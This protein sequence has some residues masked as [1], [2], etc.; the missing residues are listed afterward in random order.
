MSGLPHAGQMLAAQA[1]LQPNRIGARDLDRELTFRA[2]NERA[3]RLANALI[4]MG[5][6]KGDRV[7]VFAFNRMEWA[8][9]Y[10]AV[11][12][13]GVVAVPINFRLTPNEALFICRDCAISAV[14]AEPDL[15]PTVDAIRDDL[16]LASDRFILMG[17]TAAPGW[18]AYEDVLLKGAA[19]DPDVAIDSEDPWCLM[20]TSGTTGNPKGAIRSHRGMAMLALMTQ[21]ELGLARRDDALLVM[22]MCHANSLNFFTSFLAIGAAVT[23]FS[24][25]SFDP[26]LCLSTIG[27]IGVTFSSMVPTHYMMMLD[28]PNRSA[29]GFERVEKLMVSSAPARVE[30]KRA[31]MEMF[32]R[33]KLFELYGSTEAGWV[34]F[35]HPDEL[36]DHLGTVGREVTGSA[37]IRMLDDDGNE[38]PDGEVG[39]LYSCSPYAF[40]GYWNLP[41]KTAEAFRGDYLTVGDMALR[42]EHGFIKL[43]DRKKN[44][45]ITGGENVYP[46]EVESVLSQH[47]AVRDV[48][49]VGVED[50]QW[51]ERVAAAVVC[52]PGVDVSADSLLS[53]ARDRLAGHKRPREIVFLEQDEMPRNTTGKILHRVLRDMLKEQATDMTENQT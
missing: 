22:P 53:W 29:G 27:E 20:Y 16:H 11:A 13:A 36:F 17:D 31:I 5:L 47:D 52:R 28:A 51:G 19:T 14:I 21:V 8:E 38:V 42:D 35:L 44:M 37:P 41:E 10:A 1:R 24:R 23:I 26:E 12:K 34:T 49:V 15:V 39:E 3:N 43:I 30:T 6:G 32:P 46:A 4:G 9:I 50:T 25:Q 40:E 48:A 18:L 33:S 2:W 7:A 45:I